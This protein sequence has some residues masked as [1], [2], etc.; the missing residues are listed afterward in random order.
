MIKGINFQEKLIDELLPLTNV[1]STYTQALNF[2][3]VGRCG[4]RPNF[5]HGRLWYRHKNYEKRKIKEAIP[6]V[7]RQRARREQS[8]RRRLPSPIHRRRLGRNEAEFIR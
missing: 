7:S 4:S 5:N 1:S 3:L 6:V 8:V 2:S